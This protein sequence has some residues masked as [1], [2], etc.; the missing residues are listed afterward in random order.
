MVLDHDVQVVVDDVHVRYSAPS[1]D[2]AA[3]PVARTQRVVHRLVGREPTVVVRALAG[4]SLVAR[5][6]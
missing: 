5:A 6:G 4:I 2:R 1:S 3:R